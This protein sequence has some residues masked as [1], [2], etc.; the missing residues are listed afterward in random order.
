MSLL[1]FLGMKP[2][3][4]SFARRL[5]K[6]LPDDGDWS[7]DRERN[8]LRHPGGTELSLQNMYLEFRGSPVLQRESLIRKYADLAFSQSREIPGL[9]E[10]AAR[11]IYPV[12]RSEFV[13]MTI[14]IRSRAE[15]TRFDPLVI[16]LAGDL[17]IRLVYD[18]GNTLA[19]VSREHMETWGKSVEE[20][21]PQAIANMGRLQTPEWVD[22]GRGFWQLASPESYGESMFQL[23]NV[24]AA[25]SFAADAL[26]MPCNRGVLLAADGRSEESIAAMLS[27]ATR[28]AMQEPWPMSGTVLRK[29]PAGWQEALLPASLAVQAR[30]LKCIH[31]SENYAA[32][33]ELLDALNERLGKDVFVASMTLLGDLSDLHSYCTWA[34][35][36]PALLPVSDWVA[37]VRADDR[38]EFLRVDWHDLAEVVGHRLQPTQ[39]NPSRYLVDSFPDADDW[40]ALASRPSKLA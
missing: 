20:L 34:Q 27:E 39:E 24:V 13:D 25:L 3:P 19:Y 40:R 31:I 1:E 35:G 37:V 17:R 6:A 36:V 5:L 4:E 14:A 28:C 9:W 2:T 33:K 18:Y 30:T 7:F 32:Q 12:V 29:C 10:A 38:K 23:A 8:L 21:M 22:S 26:F 16:P 11:N 15:Q